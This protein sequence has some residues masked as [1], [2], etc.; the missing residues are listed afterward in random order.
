MK[1]VNG[2]PEIRVMRLR[3]PLFPS[4]VG[5]K[6]GMDDKLLVSTIVRFKYQNRFY[7]RHHVEMI[8]NGTHEPL[9]MNHIADV[10]ERI[11]FKCYGTILKGIPV[12]NSS[13]E[14][15][16]DNTPEDVRFINTIM[17]DTNKAN[18]GALSNT[19]NT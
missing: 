8:T 4:F 7:L 15:D 17:T 11:T 12:L 1:I 6:S 14:P 13:D 2:I 18:L 3:S 5:F 19:P 16:T 10:M 9:T